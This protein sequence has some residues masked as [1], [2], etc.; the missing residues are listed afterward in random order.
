MLIVGLPVLVGG[1]LI[2]AY[3]HGDWE[4]APTLIGV[5]SCILLVGVGLSSIMSAAFP[6][7]VVRPGD[8]P[9]QQPQSTGGAAALIQGVS[10]LAIIVL[11]LPA[12]LLAL[13]GIYGDGNGEWLALWVGLAIGVVCLVGGVIGGGAIFSRRAPELLA[14]S[15]RN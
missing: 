12:I 15:G 7:P 2:C 8:N 5:S 3:L 13:N 6:Y 4:V 10:F 14:F 11:S 1:S 9:F